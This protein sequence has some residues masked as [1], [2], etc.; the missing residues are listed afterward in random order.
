[1]VSI[2]GM[3]NESTFIGAL[4]KCSQHY[5]QAI[6]LQFQKLEEERTGSSKL[7]LITH[8]QKTSGSASFNDSL[9]NV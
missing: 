6:R 4:P 5:K 3:I 9:V 1:M 7:N 8:Q 2:S